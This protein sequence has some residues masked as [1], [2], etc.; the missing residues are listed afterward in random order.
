MVLNTNANPS[1]KG[2]VFATQSTGATTGVM[3]A[4]TTY[5]K[6]KIVAF[7]DSSP[8]D[9]GTGASGS[10]LYVSY[11]NDAT[12]GDSHEYLF[13]NAT[14]W[15]ATT[16]LPIKFTAVTGNNY[17]NVT[18]LNWQADEV[19]LQSNYYQIEKSIDGINYTKVDEV[20]ANKLTTGLAAYQWHHNET[21][22]GT[23]YYRVAVDENGAITYSNT[24][25]IKAA[26]EHIINIYPNP[27][28][29]KYGGTFSIN[30]L[31]VGSKVTIKDMLG[32]L[33]YQ[34]TA[35]NSIVI[36]NGNSNTG[37]RITAGMY[38]VSA[39]GADGKEYPVGKIV[40]VQ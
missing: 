5:G 40:V 22:N 18:T 4:Y 15:L 9:D 36:W 6:G 10:T 1:I 24:V 34:T 14:I 39:I 38:L 3:C 21:I 13:M 37:K 26:F 31:D 20:V 8:C 32:R 23:V 12:V 35:S 29:A 11:K 16:T 33:C 30:G 7:G 19:S 27:A 25:A 28:P 17:N 2:V